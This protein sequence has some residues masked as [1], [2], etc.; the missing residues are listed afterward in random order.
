MKSPDLV[1]SDAEL[2]HIVQHQLTG[3]HVEDGHLCRRFATAGWK[4]S[5]MAVNAIGHLAELAWHHPELKVAYASVTV[6][7]RTHEPDGL[8]RRDV[9]L[10]RKMDEVLLWQPGADPHSDLEGIPPND[11]AAAYLRV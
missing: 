8:T 11:P 6:R 5:L 10:A 2:Q 3:W 9:A 7:L 4:A 1:L